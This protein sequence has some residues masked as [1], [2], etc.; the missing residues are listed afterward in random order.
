MKALL[1]TAAVGAV[2]IA[3]SMADPVYSANVVGFVNLTLPVGFNLICNPLQATN[4][5]LSTIVPAPPDGSTAAKWNSGAQ[6][7]ESA[8]TFVF[9]SWDE[10]MTIAPGEAFFINMSEAGTLTFV[11]EVRQGALSTPLVAGANM[12]GS[13]VPQAGLITT[14]LGYIPGDGDTAALWD[15]A[16]QQYFSAKTFVFGS[17][18]DEPVL[19]IGEGA[20]VSASAP[21]AWD[22]TFNVQ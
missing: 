18:D 3:T 6:T 14:A 19:G 15:A 16:N 22:R 12:V 9:G 1:V 4:N 7:F 11:G 17:W 21:G 5:N 2:G 10:D 20:V 13:Q 8:K